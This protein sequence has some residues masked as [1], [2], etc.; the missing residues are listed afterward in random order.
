[1]DMEK[2]RELM[3]AKLGSFPKCEGICYPLAPAFREKGAEKVLQ[4]IFHIQSRDTDIMICTYPKSGTH[5]INEVSNM[6]LRNKTKLD[7]VNKVMTIIEFIPDL[8]VLDELQSPRLLSTHFLFRYLPRKHIENG[9]K[10]IH[11]IRNPKDVCVS[12]YHHYKK[13]ATIDFRGSWDDFFEMWMFVGWIDKE[14]SGIRNKDNLRLDSLSIC[15]DGYGKIWRTD[16]GKTG[17]VGWIDKE[18][19]GI[20]NKDNLRL[21]SLSICKDGYGKIW[22]TDE[23]KTGFIFRSR[24]SD[25]MICTYPKSGTHWINEVSNMLLRNKTE[26]DSVNKVMTTIEFIPDLTVLDELQSPRLLSTHVLFRYLPRKHIENGCK[27]I[28]M[29]R[30]P[31]DD[32][33]REIKILADFLGIQCPASTVEDIAKA[34]SFQNMKQHKID[35]TKDLNGKGFIYR[36]GEIGS[37]KNHFT[38]AQNER[39]DKQCT[40][41]FKDSTYKLTFE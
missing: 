31:K 34:T 30:N 10:I 2:I 22:R 29:I 41:R 14:C 37:W 19:S 33:N 26:L 12:F 16:E 40:E 21:D 8:T 27:I 4:D 24:D 18:C 38:V 3:K 35:D 36:K 25:I 11:M 28:H 6:L 7:S 20:R 39:F 9:C 1:M 23:G 15:K 5:W 17:F 13:Q 32:T